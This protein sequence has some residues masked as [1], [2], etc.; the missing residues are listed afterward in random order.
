MKGKAT[1]KQKTCTKCHATKSI[2]MFE[3]HEPMNDGY[4]NQCTDCRNA[5]RRLTQNENSRKYHQS[6]KG[7][8]ARAKANRNKA[9]KYPQKI[10]ARTALRNAVKAGKI[11]R[12]ESCDRCGRLCRPDGHHEDY[13]KLCGCATHAISCNTANWVTLTCY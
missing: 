1:M 9:N 3:K 7:K 13:D 10:R 8:I 12:P 6:L 11:D 5:Y 4:R 2:E